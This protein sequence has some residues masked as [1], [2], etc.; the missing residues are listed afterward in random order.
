MELKTWLK[1]SRGRQTA[2]ANHLGK[3]YSWIYQIANG[4]KKAPLETAIKIAQFTNNCVSIE[5]IYE[6]YIKN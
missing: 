2:L 5:S 1:E 6:T 3:S 4:Q